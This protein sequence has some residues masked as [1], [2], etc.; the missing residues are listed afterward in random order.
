[1]PLVLPVDPFK[2]KVVAPVFVTVQVPLAAVFPSMPLIVTF[3]PVGGAVPVV[4]VIGLV[5][6]AVVAFVIV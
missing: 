6:V 4:I 5:P 3:D 2:V 1:M